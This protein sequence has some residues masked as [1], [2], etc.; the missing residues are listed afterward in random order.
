MAAAQSIIFDKSKQV[1]SSQILK[2][3]YSATSRIMQV[4]FTNT[5]KYQYNDVSLKEY[6]TVANSSSVGASFNQTIKNYKQFR[7]VGN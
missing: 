7:K 6:E 4:T 5:S 3:E 2:V 1:V